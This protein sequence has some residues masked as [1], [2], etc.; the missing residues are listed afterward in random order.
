MRKQL[1]DLYFEWNNKA[2][3][4]LT[5]DQLTPGR[6]KPVIWTCAK[7]GYS[8]PST[9]SNRLKGT[10]CPRCQGTIPIPGETD[11]KTLF[12]HIAEEWDY[13]LNPKNPE[14]Y[15]PFSNSS[16][17]W[18][19]KAGHRWEEKIN[20]RT[21]NGLNCPFC[22]GWRPIAGVNDLGTLYPW[23]VQEWDQEENGGLTPS[24]VFPKSNKKVGWVCSRGHKW[25]TKIYHRTDGTG[26]PYCAGLKPIIGETGLETLKPDI[27]SQ[28]HPTKNGDNLPSQYTCFSHHEA[29]WICKEGHEWMAPIYRRS[30]GC[31][32][33]VCNGK[34][35]ISGVNDLESKA[36]NLAKEW[37]YCR[38]NGISPKQVALH[39]NTKYHW[40]CS[41]CGHFWKASPNN[42]ANGRGCPKCG[43]HCVDS[44][45]NSFAAMN[46]ALIEQWD[47]GRNAPLTAWDVAAFDNRDYYWICEHGHSWPTSPANRSLGTRCPYCQG[48]L[49]IVGVNDFGIVC[50]TATNEWH[51]TKNGDRLPENY[52]PNSHEE[53]WWMCSEGHE[54]Q[55]KIYE[56]AN[57]NN[58]PFCNDRLPVIGKSDLA[59][60]HPELKERWHP[61]NNRPPES[62]F[63]E[64]STSIWWLCEEGH[65]FRAPIR[66]MVLR[67]RCRACE[68]KRATSC[69]R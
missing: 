13:S 20:N 51:P 6:R 40:I 47:I 46:H 15:L 14:E 23:L 69:R 60:L 25:K 57:G 45:V 48:K 27:A 24:D 1:L 49:P 5:F 3:F 17:T 53:I 19:C 30:R 12:P 4:P 32:C 42:R 44:E 50:P 41:L 43:G 18:V 8:W 62:Y 33:S 21:A 37:D 7:C 56:R 58:C 31:G 11:L 52:L 10:E 9:V 2:N 38:N 28:W 54:W 66:E 39:S 61:K 34:T 16:V 36:P 68:K 22:G 65:N 29:W 26:C 64:S 63:P 55:K 67:W 59:T 35:I